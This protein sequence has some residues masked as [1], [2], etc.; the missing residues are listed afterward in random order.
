[1][2]AIPQVPEMPAMPGLKVDG[3]AYPQSFS[4]DAINKLVDPNLPR[5]LPHKD[6]SNLRASRVIC[7]EEISKTRTHGEIRTHN[8]PDLNR[9]PLPVGLRGQSRAMLDA[10]PVPESNRCRLLTRQL[11][12]H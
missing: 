1:M 10:S 11:F 4:C 12:Y 5:A 7:Y 9:T 6:I 2:N 8:L 3:L